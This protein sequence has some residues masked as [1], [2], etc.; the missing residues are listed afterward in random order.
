MENKRLMQII[1]CLLAE[2]CKADTMTQEDYMTWLLAD[3]GISEDEINYLK[4]NSC[5]AEME[6]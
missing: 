4:A 1:L 5:F 6:D 2:I 3:V